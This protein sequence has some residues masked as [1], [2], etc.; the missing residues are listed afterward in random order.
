[1][2]VA[3][4]LAAAGQTQAIAAPPP[5]V[6]VRTV[7]AELR[8]VPHEVDVVGTVESLQSVVI[9]PQVDGVLTELLFEEGQLVS[10]GQLLALID[11]RTQ[12][13]ALAAALAQRDRDLAQ[14]RGAELDLSRYQSL[15]ERDAISQQLLDQQRALVDQLRATAQLGSAN[16]ETARANLS[17]TRIVSPVS[18]RVGIRRVDAGNIVRTTDPDGIVSVAQVDP[19]SIVF[20]VPQ[21]QLTGLRVSANDPAGATVIAVDRDTGTE[22]GSGIITA[23]DNALDTRSGTARVRARFDNASG[24]L[25]PGTFVAVTMR[26]GITEQGVV[27]PASAVRPGVEG[28]F[29]YT[30]VEGSARRVPVEVGYANDQVAVIESGVSPGDQVVSDGFSRL[31]DKAPV[32]VA[33]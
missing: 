21:T 30:V 16:I 23:F 2:P 18:G 11:D 31:R 1:V 3:I 10:Q 25:A 22:L 4:G 9:R 19:I 29:V 32:V 14:L 15:V 24:V 12:Q 13:A 6:P 5:P 17:F 33:P 28:R 8:D 20:P 27:L 7:L 26:A